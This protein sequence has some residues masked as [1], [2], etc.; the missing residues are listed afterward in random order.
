VDID[1]TFNCCRMTAYDDPLGTAASLSYDDFARLTSH[2]DNLGNTLAYEY[3]GMNRVTKVTDHTSKDTTYAYD[4]AGRVGTITY[5]PSG[6]NRAT[7]YTYD[8]N[9]NTATSTY[10]NSYKSTFTY[11]N[12][13][14][15]TQQKL[16]NTVPATL[17]QY[18]YGYSPGGLPADT[19]GYTRTEANGDVYLIAYDRLNRIKREKR[20]VEH[21]TAAGDAD[22]LLAL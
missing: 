17:E 7:S 4:K 10:S 14:R 13:N 16:E 9:S 11:D 3:D 21:V 22:S 5:D 12:G 15:V 1:F 20:L 8:A 19:W 2:T 6:A 18:D